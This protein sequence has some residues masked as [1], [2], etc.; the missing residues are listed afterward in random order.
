MNKPDPTHPCLGMFEAG[1]KSH[2]SRVYSDGRQHY[3][4]RC[5]EKLTHENFSNIPKNYFTTHDAG[6]YDLLE[7]QSAQT[8]YTRTDLPPT[9][10]AALEVPDIAAMWHALVTWDAAHRT[11]KNEPLQVAFELGQSALAALK[12]NNND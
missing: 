3:C 2:R 6:N 1:R 9:L 5:G 11:G 10:A 4:E 8:R 7:R 12:R